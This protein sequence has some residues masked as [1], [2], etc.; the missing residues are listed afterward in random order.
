[1][2]LTGL[3]GKFGSFDR[4]RG[5]SFLGMEVEIRLLDAQK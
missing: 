4:R 5:D 1:M 2:L 3:A